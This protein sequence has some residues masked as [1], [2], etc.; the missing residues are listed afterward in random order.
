MII[1]LIS[2]FNIFGVASSRITTFFKMVC[3]HY[4]IWVFSVIITD[5]VSTYFTRCSPFL[6]INNFMLV[7]MQEKS[8]NKNHNNL[9]LSNHK[10]L[11]NKHLPFT[12]KNHK[13]YLTNPILRISYVRFIET[14]IKIPFFH[15]F[16]CFPSFSF[17]CLFYFIL[18]FYLPFCRLVVV[19][20]SSCI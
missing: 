16:I 14:T 10:K 17:V 9:K 8:T 11:S 19:G 18:H 3:F 2:I 1:S 7:C 12:Y 20:S 6:T 15:Y 5:W 13:N 4:L